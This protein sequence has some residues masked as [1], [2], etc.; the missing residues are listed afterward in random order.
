MTMDED[1]SN[2]KLTREEYEA[3][4]ARQT[5]RI[6][7]YFRDS[8]ATPQRLEGLDGLTLEQAQE[9]CS[10]SDT[11]C[12]AWFDGYTREAQPYSVPSEPVTPEVLARFTFNGDK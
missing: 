6:M 10:R 11:H 4:K 12:D 5:Y 7:R 2:R 3:W 9:H 8:N 1:Y